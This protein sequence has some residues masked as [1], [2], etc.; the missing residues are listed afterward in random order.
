MTGKQKEIV[1]IT[2]PQ[3][4][5]LL[6]TITKKGKAPGPEKVKK[7]RPWPEQPSN[8]N[9]A[10][11]VPID[12]MISNNESSKGGIFTNEFPLTAKSSEKGG[13]KNAT[14]DFYTKL[15]RYAAD[16][17][18]SDS[19]L[20]VKQRKALDGLEANIA[21]LEQR[22]KINVKDYL[23]FGALQTPLQT[24]TFS[25]GKYY[26][27]LNADGKWQGRGIRI[28]NTGR[29]W[30]GYWWNG[31]WSTGN[32]IRIYSDDKIAVGEVYKKDGYGQMRYRGT[33]YYKN[34]TEWQY[35]L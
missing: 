34:G 23:G 1:T 26:G 10:S 5:K 35:D 30:I 18:I 31:R 6:K 19:D 28:E 9:I 15:L 20:K 3:L 33:E 7:H 29:I 13:K 21:T 22:A 11:A 16:Q 32:Y 24:K 12:E 8:R 25:N 27:E 2:V 17:K 4:E 14:K